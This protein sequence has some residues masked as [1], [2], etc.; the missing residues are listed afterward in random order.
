MT[1][2][3]RLAAGFLCAALAVVSVPTAA[4]TAAISLPNASTLDV[5]VPEGQVWGWEFSPTVSISVTALGIFDQDGDGL[6][7]VHSIAI[8]NADDGS[9]ITQQLFPPGSGTD[10]IDE[11]RYINITPVTLAGDGKYIVGVFYPTTASDAVVIANFDADYMSESVI[12]VLGGRRSSGTGF[13]FPG[14]T[15]DEEAFGPNF[16]FTVVP[17]PAAVW[18]MLGGLAM[19]G[20]LRKPMRR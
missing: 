2:H 9:V 13:A 5:E 1:D 4:M 20:G 15:P 17:L 10:L 6:N 16:Q 19:L 12:N 8:W 7:D 11:F 3:P 14:L 18:L